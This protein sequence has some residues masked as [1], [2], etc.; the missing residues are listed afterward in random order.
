VAATPEL[1]IC[2]IERLEPRGNPRTD[3]DPVKLEEIADS[4]R[5][6]GIIEPLIVER[7]N[8]ND[9]FAIIQ[10]ERRWRAAQRAGMYEVP[11]LIQELSDDVSAIEIAFAEQKHRQDWNDFEDA[12]ALDRI[13]KE[14]GITTQAKLAERIGKSDAYVSQRLFLL[15][16]PKPVQDLVQRDKLK[17]SH[18][19]AIADQSPEQQVRL[20]ELA[21]QKK[22]SPRKLRAL[23][24][25]N[26]SNEERAKPSA[27]TRSLQEKF[28]R[29]LG[30]RVSLI[31]DRKNISGELRLH[32]GSTAE[33]DRIMN[34]IL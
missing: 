5:Q 24:T 23:A 28:Q 33:F 6:H 3:F 19:I 26:L 14:R 12:V 11:V 4:I 18:V 22:L 9:R 29:K 30:C 1:I 13:M 25:P 31:F 34:L 10:G 2:P 7:I 15:R 32:F 16:V 21:V 20:A 8:G 17:L 27:N